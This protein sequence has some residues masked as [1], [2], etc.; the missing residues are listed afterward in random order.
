MDLRGE[1]LGCGGEGF[2]FRGEAFGCR[3]VVG[4]VSA[5]EFRNTQVQAFSTKFNQTQLRAETSETLFE[6]P[7][8]RR[9]LVHPI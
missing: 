8:K 4:K 5:V 7:L 9:L 3:A 1:D 6:P 2:G